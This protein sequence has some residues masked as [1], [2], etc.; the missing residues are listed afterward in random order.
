MHEQCLVQ[1]L[2]YN[3]HSLYVSCNYCGQ[4]GLRLAPKGSAK[5]SGNSLRLWGFKD[6]GLN[7]DSVI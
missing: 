7:Y 3:E 6:L 4:D 5:C 2:A 1:C